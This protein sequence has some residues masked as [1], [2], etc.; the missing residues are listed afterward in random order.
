[1]F[2]ILSQKLKSLLDGISLFQTTYNHEKEDPTGTPF[3]SITP[4][5]NEND[6][7]TTTQNHRTYGFLVRLYVQRKGETTVEDAEA[8]MRDLVDATLDELDSNWNLPNLTTKTG[9]T[10]LFMEAAPSRWGYV[11]AENE[12]RVAE[13]NVRIHFSVDINLI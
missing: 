2:R 9:Y 10:F 7:Q 13:I 4:S 8:A 1:M 3:A 11:G 5:A 6:Y 12:Y